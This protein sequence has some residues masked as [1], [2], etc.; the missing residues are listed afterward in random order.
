MKGLIKRVF[1]VFG[2]GVYRLEQNGKGQ[3]P[4]CVVTSPLRHNSKEGLD[5][6]YA[7]LE[8]AESYLDFK[9]YDHLLE[10]LQGNGIALTGKNVVDVGCGTG[11]LLMAV[12]EKS[13]KSITGFEYSEAALKGACANLPSGHFE[14]FDVYEG[15]E[16]QFDIL[17]CIEVLEHLLHPD[18]A[19]KNMMRMIAPAGIALLTVPNGRT[20]TFDGHINFWSPESWEVFIKDICHGFEIKT[21]V[22]PDE[23][24]NFAIIKR[25]PET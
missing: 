16:R 8:T 19:L 15:D 10:F 4:K 3:P 1:S 7:D 14:R 23:G 13:P 5:Q 25:T 20:D 2:V 11:R 9:F 22:L 24:C 21:G 17:F 18:K 6:F 12:N